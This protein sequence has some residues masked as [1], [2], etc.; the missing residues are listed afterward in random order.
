MW[1]EARRYYVGTEFR[2]ERL[3]I[4]MRLYGF[5]WGGGQERSDKSLLGTPWTV[6]D[7]GLQ[8]SILVRHYNARASIIIRTRT[9]IDWSSLLDEYSGQGCC[10]II[11]IKG[12]IWRLSLIINDIR[13]R[14]VL[15]KFVFPTKIPQGQLT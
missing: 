10:G 15:S 11:S 1:L 4:A 2:Y 3:K 12:W 8:R 7:G 6:L 9:P 13:P 14:S 5:F